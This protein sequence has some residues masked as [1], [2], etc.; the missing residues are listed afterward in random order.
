VNSGEA[1]VG[2]LSAI[3]MGKAF[4]ILGELAGMAEG[5]LTRGAE[6]TVAKAATFD[7]SAFADEIINLN[8]ATNGGGVLLNGHPSTAIN[9]TMY[10]DAT[11]D[12]GASIFRSI[13]AGHMFIDGTK[14]AVAA[15][16]SFAEQNGLKTAGRE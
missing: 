12:Q 11:A 15:F 1:A 6:Q 3:P 13:S 14:E 9:T 4:Q 10:Y 16:Q 8:K 7:P 2:V 5:M